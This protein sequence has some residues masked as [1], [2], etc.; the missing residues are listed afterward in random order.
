M[1]DR[2]VQGDGQLTEE[3]QRLLEPDFQVLN[4]KL[5][6]FVTAWPGTDYIELVHSFS[7]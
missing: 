7:V 3:G 4:Q 2:I 6:T 1:R 5:D